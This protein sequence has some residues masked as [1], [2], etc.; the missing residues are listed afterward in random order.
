MSETD[1]F[2][3]I[4]KEQ[5]WFVSFITEIT[6]ENLIKVKCKDIESVVKKEIKNLTAEDLKYLPTEE[7]KKFCQVLAN[8]I[9]IE[10]N[11]KLITD[12]NYRKMRKLGYLSFKVTFSGFEV[13]QSKINIRPHILQSIAY[14]ASDI[15]N[16]KF[17][18]DFRF[19]RESPFLA[20]TVSIDYNRKEKIEWT[21]E[22]IQK[23]KK[24]LGQWICLFSGQWPDYDERL[25]NNR[26]KNQLSNRLSELHFI[27]RNSGFIYMNGENY[28]KFFESYIREKVLGSTAEL[29]TVLFSLVNIEL[30]LYNY[31]Q[32]FYDNEYETKKL[33]DIEE[34]IEVIDKLKINVDRIIS[35]KLI[36]LSYNLRQHYSAINRLLLELYS[37]EKNFERVNRKFNEILQRLN[38][39]HTRIA[40]NY[41]KKQERS[42]NLLNLILGFSVIVELLSIILT[43]SKTILIV[44][45]IFL[46]I[47]GLYFIFYIIYFFVL[48]LRY[49]K[50]IK[51]K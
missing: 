26:I 2:K 3:F 35:D 34:E 7:D 1:S 10:C 21:N 25:Y 15:I 43:D 33:K 6:N 29:R 17:K 30:L 31:Q 37:I 40:Q 4:F 12:F 28:D 16:K 38:N 50:G 44:N 13:E 8:N 5:Y 19:D 23:Y 51:N 45:S 42:F 49:R 27:T 47:V 41:S 32:K 46:G 20:F 22:E 24:E 9:N 48:N 39:I 36:L 18:N 14:K 11:H